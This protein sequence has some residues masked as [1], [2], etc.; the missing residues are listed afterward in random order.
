MHPV[1]ARSVRGDVW[2]MPIR[3][4]QVLGGVLLGIVATAV[5]FAVSGGAGP[6]V[7]P[8]DVDVVGG[9]V[10]EPFDVPVLV[11]VDASGDSVSTE[12]WRGRI[13]AVFFGYTSCPDICPLTL[14]RVGRYRE[15]LPPEDRERL[16]VLFVSVDPERDTPERIARYVSSLPGGI[17]GMTAPDIRNQ[18]VAW[19]VRAT[20]GE[21]M[22]DGGY[23]VDH[24]A[25]VFVLNAEGRIAATLPPLPRSNRIAPLLDALL[26]R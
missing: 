16:A 24:T 6:M 3:I 25:R 2:L 11:G 18:V 19:G 1:E 14:A 12:A 23:L 22:G 8:A 5:W 7:P 20:D 21:P 26:A 17:E 13:T 9:P 15:E 10:P 4:V